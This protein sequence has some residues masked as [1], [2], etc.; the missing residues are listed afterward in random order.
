MF[1]SQIELLLGPG[2][3]SLAPVLRTHCGDVADRTFHRSLTPP[4]CIIWLYMCYVHIVHFQVRVRIA[5]HVQLY[6][7]PPMH[8]LW[9]NFGP[10]CGVKNIGGDELFFN[11]QYIFKNY[12]TC[13]PGGRGLR[14]LYWQDSFNVIASPLDV[15]CHGDWDAGKKIVFIVQ[16][17]CGTQLCQDWKRLLLFFCQQ[18]SW[19][20]VKCLMFGVWSSRLL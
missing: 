14:S 10:G 17:E 12:N 6:S 7:F 20:E 19:I 8:C 2:A 16:N 9:P 4:W 18:I 5:K 15:C 3:S 1:A 13:V 11:A